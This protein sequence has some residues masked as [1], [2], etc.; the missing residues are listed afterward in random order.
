MASV[1]TTTI[2]TI[3]HSTHEFERFSALLKEFGI[4]ALGDVRSS[5][6]S[7]MFSQY[8]REN[9][10]AAL[11]ARG[12]GYVFLG[13]DLGAR[14][15]NPECYINGK[16]QYDRIAAT[17]GFKQAIQRV[18]AGA[19]RQRIAL[20]CAEKDPLECHRTLLVARA[21]AMLGQ[22]VAHILA[23]GSVENHEAAM[24]RLLTEEGL[25]HRDMYLSREQLIEEACKKRER[26][27]AYVDES[28]ME[29]SEKRT[30]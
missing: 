28:L 6:Y 3:G 17:Q 5:P 7:R 26:K 14:S 16:V 25:P 8:N 10:Q 27:V 4:T 12:I 9:L 21:I 22:S 1:G 30:A 2:F 24:S 29:Q 18:I 23:D 19:V 20:M 15:S 13:S 11:K